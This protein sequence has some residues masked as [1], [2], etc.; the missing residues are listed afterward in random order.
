MGKIAFLFPGQGAQYVGMGK[1]IAEKHNKANKVFN[2]SSEILNLDVK[3][4]C[5]QGPNE[6]LIKTEFTQP[7]ILTTTIAILKV[8]EEYEI[9][10]DVCAGLSLGEYSALVYS[11]VLSF[12]DA[13]KLVRKRGKFM[14]DAVPE[15]KGTMAAILGL[16][17]DAIIE[18]IEKAS[19]KGVV[20]GANY[21]CP[22]QI[23][24]SG[25]VEAVKEA[26][27]LA[28]EKGAKKAMLLP[29]S[30]PFHCSML[31]GAGEKLGIELNK[32]KINEPQK[33]IVSNV[34]ANYVHSSEEIK[35]LLIKQVSMPVLWEQSVERM[36]N[37]GVDTLIEIGPGK[38][39]SGFA[40]KVG[41][42]Y[43][44][45]LDYYNVEN[46]E[47]LESLMAKFKHKR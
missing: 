13:V 5:F 23:V 21:N 31:K 14:Q 29:V 22:G 8:I 39:L 41:K 35:A 32:I 45:S 10:A 12:E 25:E 44:Y 16:D 28:K 37:D 1:E 3:K 36:I 42:K 30:A 15:G 7:A 34:T 43:N 4:L 6:D 11:K 20:E 40:K 24:L 18:V 46:A 33:E 19:T 47:T 27:I 2:N 9:Y 38:T 17:N 26:C